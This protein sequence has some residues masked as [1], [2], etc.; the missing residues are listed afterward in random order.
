[1]IYI[2]NMVCPRCI[3]MVK[4]VFDQ[5]DLQSKRIELGEVILDTDL[6]LSKKEELAEQLKVRGFELLEDQKSK[7]ISQI[8]A[9]IVEQV[10]HSVKPIDTNFST[11]ISDK[12]A[13]E[14]SS[15]SKLFSSVE[16]VTIEKYILQQK[17]E[18]VKEL[19]FYNEMSLSQIAYQL[20]YSSVA[21]LSAQFKKETG[22]TPSLFKKTRPNR[23]SIDS[24]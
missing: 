5:L 11:L 12:L 19:L 13:Q 2:K 7:Q 14:Y 21:H 18:K 24:I 6:T 15:L 1:M 17:V 3:E 9:I 22:M 4:H 20:G 8:K 23:K 10:H 16:G